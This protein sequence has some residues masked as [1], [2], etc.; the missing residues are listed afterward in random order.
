MILDERGAPVWYKRTDVD[1]IDF[2]RLSN[3]RSA[4]MPLLGATFGIEHRLAAIGSPTSRATCSPSTSPRTRVA[5]P[6]D[7]HDYVELPGGGC[8]LL[9]YPLG[10]GPAAGA[11]RAAVLRRRLDRRR[12]DPRARLVGRTGVDWSA[13]DHFSYE[14]VTF[15]QRFGLYP[16]EPHGGE[17]DVFHLNS[18]ALVDDG[19]GDYIVSARHLDAIFRVDRATGDIDL[20]ARWRAHRGSD[21]EAAAH[22]RRRPA[23]RAAAPARRPP[24]RQ[25]ADVVRQPGRHTG[26]ARAVA[27]RIDTVAG[28]AT[29]L[30]EI[31]DPQGRPSPGLGSVRVPG[32]RLDP[33]VLGWPAA[34]VPGVRPPTAYRA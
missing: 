30:W 29:M 33:R 16:S 12:R 25:R 14:E 13:L 26:P 17:V 22:D 34:D 4:Y 11:A 24:H 27:Y 15:P 10:E 20:E 3:G 23:R 1:V 19:S 18:L 28:T 8:S 6:V 5:I 31:R 21:P 2:K 9:S 7:H 32:R